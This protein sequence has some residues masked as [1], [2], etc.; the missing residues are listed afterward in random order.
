MGAQSSLLL[1]GSTKVIFIPPEAW[2]VRCLEEV[3]ALVVDLP[4]MTQDP[5]AAWAATTS[6]KAVP[7]VPTMTGVRPDSDSGSLITTVKGMLVPAA[8]EKNKV[9][10]PLASALASSVAAPSTVT[11]LEVEICAAPR[12]D[13]EISPSD[14]TGWIASVSMPLTGGTGAGAGTGGTGG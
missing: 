3:A 13:N 1:S 2:R 4:E 6:D 9:G 8:S 11:E 12:L 5:S 14:V 10:G 7:S